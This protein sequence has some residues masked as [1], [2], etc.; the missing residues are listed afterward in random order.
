MNTR[1]NVIYLRVTDNELSKIE[2]IAKTRGISLSS[3]CRNIIL[4]NLH[5]ELEQNYDSEADKTDIHIIIDKQVL[6]QIDTNARKSLMSRSAYIAKAVIS[7]T[8]IIDGLKDFT[9][10]INR[11]G[12]NI[13]QIVMLAN[14]G[15]MKTV[16][17][18]EFNE[19]IAK[20]ISYLIEIKG[21]QERA[22]NRKGG[23]KEREKR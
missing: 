4:E 23:R 11:L 8:I 9:K 5:T 20:V 18:G 2:E 15:I 14:Q 1:K 16:D 10:E 6:K 12:S 17:F 21:G 19:L 3:L 13:N 22:Y 7:N